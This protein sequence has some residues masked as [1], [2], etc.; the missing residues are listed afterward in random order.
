MDISFLI[1][2]LFAL[3]ILLRLEFLF[4]IIYVLFGV[5][6]LARWWAARAP[7]VLRVERVYTDHAFLGERVPVRLQ[8]RNRGRLPIPWLRV[9]ESVPLE[10]HVPNFVRRVV[11][12][13]SRGSVA[14]EYVLECRQ[15]GYYSLG[16]VNLNTGDLFGLAEAQVQEPRVDHITVYPRIIPLSRL[17]ISSQLPFGAVRTRQ[18]LFEDPI[19]MIGLR[20]YEAGDPLHRIH[21]KASA[22]AGDLLV[23]KL[24]SVISLETA[25]LL[26]LRAEEYD[27]QQRINA[28]EWAIVVAASIAHYLTGKRQPVGLFTNGRDPL[29]GDGVPIGL[30]PRSG[31]ESLV[32]LL[33]ILARIEL[34]QQAVVPF[35]MWAREATIRL[36][37]GTTVIAITPKGDEDTCQALH[38]LQQAGLNAILIVVEPSLQFRETERRARYLGF[39]AHLVA[40][41]KDLDIWRV[42]E[43]APQ[44]VR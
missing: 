27:P 37:W 17:S 31:Q 14:L 8:I 24:D 9:N 12:L 10:L 18:R 3:F 19:R 2:L 32:K 33:E 4:Y 28:S 7:R 43:N 26:N 41:E 40:W 13:P 36:G 42:P 16:P 23:T 35:A 6:V 29:S 34:N 5:W 25:I 15:R 44:L 11:T 20:D 38:R 21:W 39:P 22:H 30:P 1:I